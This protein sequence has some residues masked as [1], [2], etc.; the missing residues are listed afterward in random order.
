MAAG[1][2]SAGDLDAGEAA[3]V[4]VKLVGNPHGADV[5]VAAPPT[6]FQ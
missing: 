2:G 3:T 4:K 5:H 1:Q 6:I